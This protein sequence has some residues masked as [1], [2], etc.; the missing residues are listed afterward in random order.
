MLFNSLDYA[1]F[2]PLFFAL[3]WALSGRQQVW[4]NLLVVAGSYYFY[5][6]WDW[7]FLGLIIA[8]TLIDYCLSLGIASSGK[9]PR[10]KLLLILSLAANLGMLGVFKY[11]G[12]FVDSWIEVWT[13]LGF[14]MDARTWSIVLPVGISFYTF[15][16]LSYTIDVYRG[17][18]KPTR[19][20]VAYA[21]YVSFFPQL[22]AGPIERA[23]RLLPQFQQKR[24][25]DADL[26]IDGLRQ[27]IWGL[28]KKVVVADGCAS[29]ANVIFENAH[30]QPGSVLAL[31]V[32]FFAFQ[33][34]GDFSGYSDMAIGTGK[35]LGIRLMVN[36]R[37]PYFSR[38]IAEF[39]RRWHISLST[40]F[41]DYVYIPLGG[42]RQRLARNL[43]NVMVV[44][45][46]SGL[47]HGANWTFIV[48]GALNALYFIPLMVLAR[49][50]QHTGEIADGK[51]LPSIRE[52]SGILTTFALTCIAWVWFR[53]E[54]TSDAIVYFQRMVSPSLFSFP[55]ETLPRIER[56]AFEGALYVVGL[57]A[58]EWPNRHREHPLEGNHRFVILAL[59]IFL[60]ALLGTFAKDSEFIY[61]QF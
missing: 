59:T 32:V 14:Q 55:M 24:S 41:R 23:T 50:R 17:N 6:Q 56:Y 12:F 57:V 1:L 52:A 47:W 16:T 51:W 38:D 7:R 18:L 19:D 28:F 30:N 31:G 54:S 46:V 4:Q 44:F 49:N 11:A 53:S 5:A 58:I 10:R 3:Y 39:W 61:F 29:F 36:F 9:L 48:W 15:Q 60:T 13:R 34:Y 22:I 21:A 42:S 37:Y 45:V 33:I 20:L 8:S 40:W 2:L 26:A 43:F 35:M 27:F 25:F